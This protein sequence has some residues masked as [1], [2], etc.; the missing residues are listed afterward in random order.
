MR[1][2]ISQPAGRRVRVDN[3]YQPSPVAGSSRRHSTGVGR[4]P[5]IPE[6]RMPTGQND[7]PVG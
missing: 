2:T 3:L 5:S 1:T 7:Q 6:C 4:L